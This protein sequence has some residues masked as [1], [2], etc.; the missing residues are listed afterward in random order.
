M[1]G[2]NHIAKGVYGPHE[3]KVNVLES[4][5]CVRAGGF[6]KFLLKAGI[7]LRC[8]RFCE[9]NGTDPADI[10]ALFHH[11]NHAINQNAGLAGACAGFDKVVFVYIC[12]NLPSCGAVIVN[13]IHGQAPFRFLLSALF[14]FPLLVLPCKSCSSRSICIFFL[15]R[16][17]LAESCL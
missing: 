8:R 12:P 14:S 11:A 1:L 16:Q 7:E 17:D 9:G 5:L 10:K 2:Q 15:S 3:A 6:G 13:L 4:L